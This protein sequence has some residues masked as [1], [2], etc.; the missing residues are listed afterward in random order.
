[1][2]NNILL[3]DRLQHLK[4]ISTLLSENPYSIDLYIQ[5]SQAYEET[6]Y[7]ELAAGA[8]YKALL[9]IDAILDEDE[10]C[11]EASEAVSEAIKLE[12]YEVRCEVVKQ[13]PQL[14]TKLQQVNF[15]N[16]SSLPKPDDEE[17]LV[18]VRER[19]AVRV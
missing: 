9:L 17:V 2:T 12:S 19:Y 3:Q 8:V 6:G 16:E 15:G 7:P 1:M 5:L 4:H 10:Y 14:I 18:W 13:H 11:E